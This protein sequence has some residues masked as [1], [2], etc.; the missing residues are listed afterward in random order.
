MDIRHLQY[1]AAVARENSFTKAAEAL[2]VTQPT[3]SKMVRQL[4]TELNAELFDRS[5]KKI[6]L[7]DAGET[8]YR[9]ALRVLSSLDDMT[10]ELD[11]VLL[12][13]K[14]QIRLGL[15]PMI[16]SR[17]FPAIME[18]FHERYPDIGFQL[19][20]QGGKAIEA[21]VRG[22]E[23]DVGVVLLPVENR[24][25]FELQ[26]LWED[27][28]TVVVPPSHPLA[29]RER[30]ALRELAG[31]SFLLFPEPFTLHH[32]VKRAC[33]NAGFEPN[34]V[35]E[36]SQWDFM[37]GMVSAGFGIALLPRNIGETLDPSRFRAIPLREPAISWNLAVI[38]SKERYVSHA[39]R[40]W[41]RFLREEGGA[42]E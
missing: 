15:P 25:W 8:V 11:D 9:S 24:E 16:G 4:E 22:G 23:L 20:E 38:W 42:D 7:T 21:N 2:H 28:L 31:E 10:A 30:L 29:P 19:F 37:T 39:A 36:T 18:R 27:E 35:L 33:R 13:R 3:L 5:G 1:F 14:G 32:T 41:I 6:R 34:V 26:P 12:L 40:A 17:F